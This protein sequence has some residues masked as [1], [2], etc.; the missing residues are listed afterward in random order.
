[1]I[2]ELSGAPVLLSLAGNVELMGGKKKKKPRTIFGK[3]LNV[4]KWAVPGYAVYRGG[5]AVVDAAKQKR[6]KNIRNLQLEKAT[7]AA[8]VARAKAE[9]AKSEQ[10]AATSAMSTPAFSPAPVETYE[11][12]VWQETPE[13]IIEST[14]S[15]LEEPTEYEESA[16]FMGYSRHPDDMFVGGAFLPGAKK[17]VSKVKNTLSNLVNSGSL[18]VSKSGA[19]YVSSQTPQI[20]AV[21]PKSSLDTLKNP[22]VLAIGAG[23]ILLL[24]LAK[25]R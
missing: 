15:E 5:K 9:R 19:E 6:E 4:A 17:A 1:M 20:T 10:E 7:M 14:E 18:V 2:T 24:A 8:K 21:K 16:E 22:K 23:A 25:R 11:E 3:A 12:S 13:E